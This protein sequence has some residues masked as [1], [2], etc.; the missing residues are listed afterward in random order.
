MLI[1][2]IFIFI[3]ILNFSYEKEGKNG[4]HDIVYLNEYD[5]TKN[6]YNNI[7]TAGTYLTLIMKIEKNYD[8]NQLTVRLKSKGIII[9]HLPMYLCSFHPDYFTKS[10][11]E[12]FVQSYY[13]INL[14]DG[15][16]NIYQYYFKDRPY[17][18]VE[19]LAFYPFSNSDTTLMSIFVFPLKIF[20]LTDL[21]ELNI[22]SY[23]PNSTIPNNTCFYIR[24]QKNLTEAKIQFKVPHNS[25]VNFS[26]KV[27]GF[28][29]I[30][31]DKEIKENKDY[32]LSTNLLKKDINGAYDNYIYEVKNTSEHPYILIFTELLNTLDYLSISIYK[33]E[34]DKEKE[35][36]KQELPEN[37]KFLDNDLNS[38]ILIIIIVILSCII[39]FSV[40]NYIFKRFRKKSHFKNLKNVGPEPILAIN[41]KC[42]KE[43]D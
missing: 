21:N 11:C 12:N 17:K 22:N 3:P 36:D 5:I 19:Y 31:S 6:T 38:F 15:G 1:Y 30:L 41:D 34:S 42:I 13:K 32:K 10:D 28:R 25:N 33:Q 2:F 26:F 20:N 18:N 16:Y 24:V 14:K 37:S 39:L 23:Y 43:K 8:L 27:N 35:S 40:G 4:E 7:V 9:N 29:R